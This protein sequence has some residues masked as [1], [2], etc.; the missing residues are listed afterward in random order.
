MKKLFMLALALSLTTTV[1]VA[2]KSKKSKGK[3]KVTA[4]AGP[5]SLAKADNLSV[6]YAKNNLF[7]TIA[8]SKDTISLRKST[9]SDPTEV[10]VKPISCSGNQMYCVTWTEKKKQGDA[11]T[12]LEDITQKHTMIVDVPSKAKVLEN[13]EIAN[14]ITEKVYLSADKY[15]SETQE[16]TR[17][18]GFE[19]SVAANGE[20]FLKNKSTQTKL[21][22]DPNTKKFVAKK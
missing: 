11:K 12:K 9:L 17:R 16:K 14:H 7:V 4:V 22:Y 13:I 1:S 6:D 2:Q 19:C 3:A 5:K 18:E 20:V 8:P 15:V 10:A 21:V